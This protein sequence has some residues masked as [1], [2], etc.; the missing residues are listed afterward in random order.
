MY[1]VVGFINRQTVP[2]SPAPVPS[3]VSSSSSYYLPCNALQYLQPDEDF[4]YAPVSAI[5]FC[6]VSGLLA[7]GHDNGLVSRALSVCLWTDDEMRAD[8]EG[9]RR[10]WGPHCGLPLLFRSRCA[11][12]GDV[13]PGMEARLT[14]GSDGVILRSIASCSHLWWS[15]AFFLPFLPSFPPSLPPARMSCRQVELFELSRT[16][17]LLSHQIIS[18]ICVYEQGELFSAF[19]VPLLNLL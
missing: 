9:A 18:E 1:L 5:D 8:L 16:K 7:V 13:S 2:C 3:C 17:R 12:F 15:F 10:V 11:C 14:A 4:T 19:C 6:T